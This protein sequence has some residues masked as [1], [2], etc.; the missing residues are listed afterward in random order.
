MEYKL[1]NDIFY[2]K[3]SGFNKL[4]FNLLM[5][6]SFKPLLYCLKSYL[7]RKILLKL[8]IKYPY[9]LLYVEKYKTQID[10][11]LFGYTITYIQFTE[12]ISL[13]RNDVVYIQLYDE[14]NK[15]V[16]NKITKILDNKYYE[17]QKQQIKDC[18]KEL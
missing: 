6:I 5:I 11:K 7:N 4:L 1:K 18:T 14:G 12:S 16:V 9:H 8:L 2:L 15:K 3:T 13:S 10:Y 17:H